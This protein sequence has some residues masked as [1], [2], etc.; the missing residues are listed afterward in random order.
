MSNNNNPKNNNT[1]QSSFI[2]YDGMNDFVNHRVLLRLKHVLLEV[3]QVW[4]D[5]IF[6]SK[7]DSLPYLDWAGLEVILNFFKPFRTG[8]L[9]FQI[10]ENEWHKKA[11]I[12]LKCRKQME[13]Y[14]SVEN[15]AVGTTRNNNTPDEVLADKLFNQLLNQIYNKMKGSGG[16]YPT[17]VIGDFRKDKNKGSELIWTKDDID[18][19]AYHT[20]LNEVKRIN[21]LDAERFGKFYDYMKKNGLLSQ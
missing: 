11:E 7:T 21:K 17:V 10:N 3:C 19:E 13:A 16:F 12:D 4:H 20:K 8:E 5:T 9:S 1:K 2:Q 6:T 15:M 14:V 18:W